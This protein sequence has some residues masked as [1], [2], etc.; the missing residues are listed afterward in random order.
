M[1]TQLDH[2]RIAVFISPHGYGHAARAA[3]VVEEMHDLDPAIE[4]EI[5]TTVPRWFFD[6]SLSAHF[7]YHPFVTD[8]GLVQKTPLQVDLEGTILRLDRFLPFAPTLIEELVST[9]K[10]RGCRLILCD[11]A[12]VGI[13]VAKEAGI[14]SILIENFTWDWVYEEY[15]GE[16]PEIE[17]HLHYLKELFALADVHIKT[18]PAC[19]PSGA[20][21]FTRP[22][23]RKLKRSSH[24][25]RKSL[26]VP[27]DARLAM[28]TM[29]GVPLRYPFLEKIA[30]HKEVFF[31]IPGGARTF[32]VQRNLILLPHRS[33]YHHPDLVNAADAVIG[34]AGYSTLAEVYRAGVPFGYVVRKRFR[35]SEVLA[36]FI[37]THMKGL[38]VAE[39]EFE[40]A[41]WLSR[42]NELFALPRLLPE[43]PNGAAQ[44]ARFL[45]S[46]RFCLLK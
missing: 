9:V 29:G 46:S 13:L 31:L 37:D 21:L 17:R 12:P 22:V 20:D 33:G 7:K 27:E 8:I 43:G 4:F 3:A 2:P 6:D 45:L 14:P 19:S 32:Q 41:S 36:S 38:P 18:A 44:V 26:G 34:K 39:N 35:E 15:L 42:L 40:N 11:I 1:R 5:F 23:S 16:K 28:I 24:E 10:A 25:I 30:Q